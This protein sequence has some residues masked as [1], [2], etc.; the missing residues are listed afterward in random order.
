MPGGVSFS[1]PAD[2]RRDDGTPVDSTAGWF[3]G[4]GYRVTFDVGRFGERLDHLGKEHGV[5]PRSRVVA[6]RPATEIAF[7]PGDEPFGWA[8]VIQVE[9]AANRTLTIRVS[10][11]RLE[12]CDF[13][14]AVFESIVIA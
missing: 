10:C 11:G 9:L 4:E 6:A 14:D 3:D 12:R 1:L 2:A 5:A 13:A 8:R 7:M